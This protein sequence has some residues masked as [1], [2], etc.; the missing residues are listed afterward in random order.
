MLQ[1]VLS[2]TMA[3]QTNQEIAAMHGTTALPRRNG[4][5]VFHDEWE[6]RIF[7]IGVVLCEKG[8]Y[9]WDDFRE[10]LI[11]SIA[12]AGETAENPDLA[13]T[14]YYEHWLE[15]LEKTL[16]NRGIIFPNAS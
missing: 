7:A 2:K 1:F 16:D 10:Q 15:A 4:E 12:R 8:Y 11:A 6:R 9:A 14:G 5:L 13:A 3:G